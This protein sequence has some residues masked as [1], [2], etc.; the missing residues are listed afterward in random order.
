M[1]PDSVRTEKGKDRA[2]QGRTEYA[3]IVSIDLLVN[4]KKFTNNI[5]NENNLTFHLKK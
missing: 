3:E 1:V 5:R 4:G 2:L